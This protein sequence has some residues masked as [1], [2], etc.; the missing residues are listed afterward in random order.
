MSIITSKAWLPVWLCYEDPSV[1]ASVE[2]LPC[3]QWE[4]CRGLSS[5]TSLP[6]FY[7]IYEELNHCKPLHHFLKI[8]YISQGV[9]SSRWGKVNGLQKAARPQGCRLNHFHEAP[10]TA[11]CFATVLGPSSPLHPQYS[12][13][14]K[15]KKKR[16]GLTTASKGLTNITNSL[17]L[18][19]VQRPY[20]VTN[21]GKMSWEKQTKPLRKCSYI[22]FLG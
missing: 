9:Q 14:G 5:I 6:H 15:K 4:Y 17:F 18:L 22:H 7:N 13:L 2:L 20:N 3:L 16:E 19:T 12:F 21:R 10:A 8:S 1:S 11:F